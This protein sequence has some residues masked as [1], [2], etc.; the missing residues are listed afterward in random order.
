MSPR[1]SGTQSL[2]TA[3]QYSSQSG[4]HRLYYR[5]WK[6]FR[7][8][9][10]T[11]ITGSNKERCVRRRAEIRS[12]S[13]HSH[14]HNYKPLGGCWRVWRVLFLPCVTQFCS[15]CGPALSAI[16]VQLGDG[17]RRWGVCLPRTTVV[18]RSYVREWGSVS[19]VVSYFH[20]ASLFCQ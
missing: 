7:K 18:A 1:Q 4:K 8:I 19:D 17:L 13:W 10:Q 14:G 3:R 11:I 9:T 15:H 20:S 5:L 16:G 12:S 2:R 6:P